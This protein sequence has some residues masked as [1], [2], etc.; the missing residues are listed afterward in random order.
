MQE[1]HHSDFLSWMLAAVALV[2]MAAAVRINAEEPR[3]PA[4]PRPAVT[5]ASEE[6]AQ[7]LQAVEF[8]RQKSGFA[9]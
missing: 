4:V 5:G 7:A 8:Q 6:R 3:P 1:Q 9:L 2:I